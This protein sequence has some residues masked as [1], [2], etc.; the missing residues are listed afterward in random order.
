[1]PLLLVALALWAGSAPARSDARGGAALAMT[2]GRALMGGS[3]VLSAS[4][5]ARAA[6]GGVAEFVGAYPAGDVEDSGAVG[7]TRV[8]PALQ[9]PRALPC[10]ES[11]AA[12][13]VSMHL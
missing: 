11:G 8:K 12:G 4:A 10:F 7:Q 6:G 9:T 5:A 1:M 3:A 13:R 2:R